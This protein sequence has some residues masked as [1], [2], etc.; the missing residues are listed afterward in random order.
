MKEKSPTI[1]DVILDMDTFSASKANTEI[2]GL[3]VRAV[4]MGDAYLEEG[5]R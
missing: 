3:P 5:D 2:E 4:I 1:G